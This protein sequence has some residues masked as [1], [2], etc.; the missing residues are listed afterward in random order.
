MVQRL[1]NKRLSLIIALV[2]LTGLAAM[3]LAGCKKGG[4]AVGEL[5]VTCQPHPGLFTLFAGLNMGGYDLETGES[6]H[7]LRTRVREALASA[8]PAL[9][10]PFASLLSQAPP[11]NLALMMVRD[12]GGPP[13]F[14]YDL[15]RGL[16]EEG[17]AACRALW[18]AAA[19]GLWEDVSEDLNAIADTLAASGA[20]A[21]RDVLAY[22]HEETSA[23]REVRILVIPLASQ[24]FVCSYLDDRASMGC[25]VLGAADTERPTTVLHQY[26]RL[27]FGDDLFRQMELDGKLSPFVAVRDKAK[28]VPLI[29]QSYGSL[30]G[31][32]QDCLIR[33]LVLRVGGG[34]EA[35]VEAE[36]DAGFTL[37][38]A[39]YEALGQFEASSETLLEALPDILAAVDA[40]A[41][42]TR[43]ES[44]PPGAQ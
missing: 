30:Q 41:V 43:M 38:P 25:I 42:L 22:C 2:V 3:P 35:A 1:A 10:T 14:S 32:V 36:Y 29:K 17:S 21:V 26:T 27:Y 12:I 39:F 20:Q 11:E 9:F 34:D 13:G 28:E 6:M 8:D 15:S 37:T 16:R 24:D 33:A 5:A 31:F 44:D 19:E 23:L 18:A 4:V 7:P 40:G